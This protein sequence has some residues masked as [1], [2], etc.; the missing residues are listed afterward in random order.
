MTTP[1]DTPGADGV[2]VEALVAKIRRV[3][4]KQ[5]TTEPRKTG[6]D[7][8]SQTAWIDSQ[9]EVAVEDYGDAMYERGKR[10]RLDV[11]GLCDRWARELPGEPEYLRGILSTIEN[12]LLVALRPKEPKP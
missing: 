8:I 7:L 1:P 10:E 4:E 11:L 12:D 5:L 2:D 3:I 9:I 6:A